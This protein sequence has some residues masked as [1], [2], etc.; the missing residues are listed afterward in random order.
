MSIRENLKLFVNV[1]CVICRLEDLRSRE[2]VC[3]VIET[4]ELLFKL[5]F[6]TMETLEL[7]LNN[8][9]YFVVSLSEFKLEG[10]LLVHGPLGPRSIRFKNYPRLVFGRLHIT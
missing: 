9:E 4:S 3:P 7:T 1:S 5:S 2:I 8:G 6:C 10:L